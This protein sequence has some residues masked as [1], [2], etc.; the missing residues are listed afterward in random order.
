MI[1]VASF[2]SERQNHIAFQP[3]QQREEF[4]DDGTDDE[5]EDGNGEQSV[6]FSMDKN[7]QPN[8]HIK[9][10]I[11]RNAK[12]LRFVFGGFIILIVLS[13][14]NS[15]RSAKHGGSMCDVT[16]Y[17]GDGFGSQFEG[18]MANYFYAQKEHLKFCPTVWNSMTHDI[19]ATEMFDFVGGRNYGPIAPM[20]T[21][22]PTDKTRMWR[23]K[24]TV[25]KMYEVWDFARKQYDSTPKPDLTWFDDEHLDIALHI[26]RGDVRKGRKRWRPL[27]V[28]NECITSLKRFYGNS[29]KSMRFHILSEGDLADFR[30]ITDVHPGMTWHLNDD[31][32]LSYHHMVMADVL[33]PALSA[34][35]R[36]AAFL[37]KN[38][39]YF[40]EGRKENYNV[41]QGCQSLGKESS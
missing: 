39:V 1:G 10:C 17:K 14:A 23:D 36:T 2:D 8:Y 34:F 9:F 4:I 33:V 16:S 7:I 30:E 29:A 28:Y 21:Y 19:N 25:D 20:N 41:W 5:S 26:R 31:V 24:R 27:S 3:V 11:M 15:E 13:F 40:L 22:H 32:K 18:M 38:K 37:S 12:W 6:G 35:S